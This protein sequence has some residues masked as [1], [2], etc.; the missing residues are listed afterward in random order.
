MDYQLWTNKAKEQITNLPKGTI[1]ELKRLFH[2]Y[3]WDSL[4][5]GERKSFGRVFANEVRDGR[6]NQVQQFQPDKKGNNKYIKL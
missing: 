3:D 2:G 4:S 1:F 5:P 6:V